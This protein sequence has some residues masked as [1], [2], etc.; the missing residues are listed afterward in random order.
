MTHAASLLI[1][2]TMVLGIILLPGMDMAL[3]L[4]ATIGGGRKSGLSA[5]AGIIAGGMCH[6]AMGALGLAVLLAAMPAA[7]DALLIAGAI[8]IA[9]I[10]LTLFRSGA[11]LGAVT[12]IKSAGPMRSFRQGMLTC[13]LNPKAYVF[14]LAI[15]PQFVRQEYG[16]VWT[17]AVIL[18]AIIAV[19]QA[20]VYGGMALAAAG[21]RGWLERNPD[22]QLLLGRLIGAVLIAAAIWTGLHGWREF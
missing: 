1:F 7:F 12:S 2:F 3:V 13:L 8:Y 9:W 5:L 17:Q 6:V 11:T 19:T 22:M 4:A 21:A 16:P 15:F 10:G 18:G 20:G 14:M